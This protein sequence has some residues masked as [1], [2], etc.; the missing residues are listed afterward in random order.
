MSGWIKLHRGLQ[1]WGWK[2]SPNHLAVFIDLI[3]EANHEDGECMGIKIPRGALTTSIKAIS[4]RSGV[5]EMRVRTILNQ[6]KLTNELTIKTTTKFTMIS[7]SKWDDYQLTNK[8]DNK[9]LTNEQQTTNKRLTTNKKL[10]T[11]EVK[12]KNTPPLLFEVE[13]LQLGE[14]IEIEDL[15]V[16]VLTAF[17]TICFKGCQP[18][19]FNIGKI[20][21]RVKEG[22]T[23]SDFIK[24]LSFMNKKWKDDPKMREYLTIATLFSGKFDGYLESAK[25]ADKPILCPFNEFL[26]SVGVPDT[27]AEIGA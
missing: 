24:T 12:N 16:K 8:A 21:A 5:S 23:Y 4:E 1:K 20:N 2:K 25:N 11:K 19:K 17:N 6:L 10:I 9:Q 18:T 26:G 15:A 14:D 27:L 13:P 22:Y 7:I 3:L